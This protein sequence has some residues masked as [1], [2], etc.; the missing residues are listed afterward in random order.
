MKKR[1][2]RAI[3]FLLMWS[4]TLGNLGLN[5]YAVE[6][7]E[8]TAPTEEITEPTTPTQ[9]P[10][11][12]TEAPELPTEEPEVPTGEPDVPTEEPTEPTEP[13]TPSPV[14]TED[15]HC[16]AKPE[17]LEQISIP[18]H[19]SR[20]AL[21]FCVGNEIMEGRGDGLAPDANITRAETAAIL[22]R[23][24][25]AKLWPEALQSYRDVGAGEWYDAEISAAVHMGLMKGT[26]N[27]TIDPDTNLTR[28]DACVLLSRAFGILPIDHRSGQH[29]RDW[30]QISAYAQTAISGLTERGILTGYTDQ[31]M[32]PQANITRAEFAKLVYETVTHLCDRAEELPA[33]GR[34]L[35]RGEEEIPAGYTLAGDLILGYGN[36]P[37]VVLSD[38][39]VSG[40]LAVNCGPEGE[41]QVT[42]GKIGQ[43]VAASCQSLTLDAKADYLMVAC[44]GCRVQ[45]DVNQVRMFQ[46]GTLTGTYGNVHVMHGGICLSLDGTADHI[47]VYRDGNTLRGEGYAGSVDLYG[48]DCE[49]TLNNGGCIDHYTQRLYQSALS[50]VQT[51]DS[52]Y[53]YQRQ[54]PYAKATMEGFVDQR[55][56]SSD[57]SYLIWVSTTTTTVNIF[58]GSKGSWKLEKTMDCALGAPYSP[59]VRGTFKTFLRD[60]EWDFESYKCRWGTYFYKGYAFHS[61][62]WAPDYSYLIDPSINCL[63]SAGCVRMYDEDCYYIY[64]SIPVGTTVVVY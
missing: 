50:T 28:E 41:V 13:E 31:T 2:I 5:G 34:V 43:L 52:W 20:N 59:T 44:P 35:Y 11:V 27:T 22:V 55:G 19:W 61:R 1:E 42:G 17:L 60:N 8:P 46:D 62:K 56:Y 49:V 45:A 3:S 39:S 33:R 4:L 24:L 63:V 18:D 38:L 6:S 15:G 29:Y 10:E 25:G 23:L 64:S 7:Q 53:G 37:G 14:I 47:Y 32:H 9:E 26:S 30:D 12:P 40:T 48:Q 16:I 58:R 36:H 21:E 57:T 54:A 51:V